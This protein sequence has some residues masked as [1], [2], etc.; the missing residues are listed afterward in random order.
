M[1]KCTVCR[2]EFVGYDQCPTCYI[3]QPGK[4]HDDMRD[5]LSASPP[6]MNKYS[7]EIKRIRIRGEVIPVFVDVYEVLTA[8]KT[9][10]P[11]MDHA[12]KKVLC[13]GSRGTKDS[14][15]DK[16]EAIDSIVRSMEMEK[17]RN[18]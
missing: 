1:N 12:A 3:D 9:E 7:R 18:E 14:L 13:A 10:C 15:Q 2:R 16:Q 5:V 4:S 11:A 17:E 8:F 6:A